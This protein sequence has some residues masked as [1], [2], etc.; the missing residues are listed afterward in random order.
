MADIT[1]G[2][3][4][5]KP[6]I[7]E[8]LRAILAEVTPGQRPYSGDSYLPAHLVEQAVDALTL[9]DQADIAAQQHAFNAL[10]AAS[11]HAARGESLLALG[12]IRRAQTH[13]AHS[14][15]GRA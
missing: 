14:M 8:A 6:T 12:R 2:T 1:L 13:L 9:A 11:W 5:Q 15:E 7:A 10:S 4:A 3:S